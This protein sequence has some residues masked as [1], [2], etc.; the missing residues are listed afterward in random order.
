[1]PMKY[2]PHP[3]RSILRDCM[4]PLGMSLAETAEKLGVSPDELSRVINGQAGITFALAVSLDRLF[5]GG[6]STWHQLQA[7]YDRAQ[8]VNKLTVPEELEPLP[9][10]PQTATVHLE[11]GRVIYTTYD[12]E[13][14]GLRIAPSDNPNLTGNPN[15][16]RVECGFVGEGPG[17][18]RIQMIYQPLDT[19]QPTLIADVVFKAFLE[20]NAEYDR[21]VGRIDAAEWNLAFEK[22]N[23]GKETM[24][25]LHAG[26]PGQTLSPAPDADKS[27]HTGQVAATIADPILLNNDLLELSESGPES[28]VDVLK[29]AEALL[30]RHTEVAGVE[31]LA[32][33]LAL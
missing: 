18:V 3:G 2:P 31:V 29:E 28:Q 33:R 13:V 22:L 23:A 11:H 25:S 15:F 5:G 27:V 10:L 16:G 19:V 12:A 1:M 6:A 9:V 30:N 20:W 8:E 7:A 21:Y 14:I 26:L 24:N 17:A 32:A 4:E